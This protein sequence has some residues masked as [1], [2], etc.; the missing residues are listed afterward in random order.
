[1]KMRKY[2]DSIQGAGSWDRMHDLIGKQKLF[3]WEMPPITVDGAVVHIFPGSDREVTLE[4]VQNE[5]RKT[6]RSVL[7][8]MPHSGRLLLSEEEGTQ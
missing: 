5:V 2:V 3:G 4:A 1:M 6:L 7:L 8:K